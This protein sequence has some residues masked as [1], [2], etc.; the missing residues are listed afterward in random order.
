MKLSVK[1]AGGD[2]IFGIILAFIIIFYMWNANY[3]NDWNLT[4][5]STDG[6]YSLYAEIAQIIHDNELPLWSSLHG[7]MTAA[8]NPISQA[9]YPVTN[10][11]CRLCYSKELGYLSYKILHYE[12]IIHL[13]ILAWG[14][15]FLIRVVGKR[16]FTAFIIALLCS[17]TSCVH[18]MHEWLYIW[19]GLVYM[20]LIIGCAINIMRNLNRKGLLYCVIGGVFLGLSGLAAPTQGVLINIVAFAIVYICYFVGYIKSGKAVLIKLTWRSLLCGLLGMGYMAV[21]LFPVAEF[22]MNACRYIPNE[23]FQVG[24]GRMSYE[25]FISEKLALSDVLTIL[26]TYWGWWSIGMILCAFLLIGLIIPA[27]WDQN[28]FVGVGLVVFSMLYG[29]G[30]IVT[31]IMYYVPFYNA[32]REPYLYTFMAIAGIA[33][34]AANGLD[35]LIDTANEKMSDKDIIRVISII[36]FLCLTG[37]ELD[38]FRSF[39]DNRK[40]DMWSATKQIDGVNQNIKDSYLQ[41]INKD[42]VSGR[43]WQW[44]SA[45]KGYPV[46]A[47]AVMGW[48]DLDAYMNPYYANTY[49]LKNLVAMDKRIQLQNVEYIVCSS[50]DDSK[51]KILKQWGFSKAV[52]FE[53][54]HGTYNSINEGETILYQKDITKGY[55]WMVYDYNIFDNETD[56]EDVASMINDNQFNPFESAVIHRDTC[57]AK[58]LDLLNT[59]DKAGISEIA[60]SAFKHN[61]VSFEVKS[62]Q[63]GIFVTSEIYAPGWNV[64]IDG[65]KADIIK[66]NLCFRGVILS[67]GDHIIEFRYMPASF[68]LG[69]IYLVINIVCSMALVFY[70]FNNKSISFERRRWINCKS[71]YHSSK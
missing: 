42:K 58:T 67:Q 57:K 32:I 13:I 18:Q 68:I 31:K 61:S 48:N 16:K 35:S 21:T 12:V 63:N 66:V 69:L 4:G 29:C 19:G 70:T 62:N 46:N 20:P 15:Y 9:F 6:H 60:L 33:I 50:L 25:A 64:Y 23:G 51:D 27:K 39:I 65:K 36:A 10:I 30:V 59:V 24:T 22:I 28:W 47:A 7:G 3:V 55:G 41:Y 8:G 71:V 11:L 1:K 14:L 17:L 5:D 43:V 40:C 2:L 38:Q 37:R 52:Q 45:E 56:I 53:G 34:I 54:C 26:F 49:Y 44:A